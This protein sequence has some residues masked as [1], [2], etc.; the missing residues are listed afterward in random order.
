MPIG[1]GIGH[2]TTLEPY[3]CVESEEVFELFFDFAFRPRGPVR[4]ECTRFCGNADTVGDFDGASFE[5]ELG[6]EGGPVHGVCDVRTGVLIVLPSFVF[7]AP[8]VA[9]KAGRG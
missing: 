4:V 2:E 5:D 7:F 8:R 6:G 3:Y 9:A 1:H